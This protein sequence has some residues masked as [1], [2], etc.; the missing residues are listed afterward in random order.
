MNKHTPITSYLQKQRMLSQLQQEIDA[1]E[2]DDKLKAD[3]EFKRDFEQ[4]L[5]KHNKTIE[6]VILI[7]EAAE[8]EPV[9]MPTTQTGPTGRPRPGKRPLKIY[10]NPKT[11]ETVKCRGTNNKIVRKW[12]EQYGDE[13]V[14]KWRID[15][16]E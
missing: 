15:V 14:E 13:E 4:V 2:R 12:R 1:M 11:G 7:Y 8:G 9:Q 10:K 16:E 6:D 5:H 3:M